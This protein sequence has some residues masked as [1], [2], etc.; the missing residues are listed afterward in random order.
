MALKIPREIFEKLPWLN[1]PDR[2]TRT[3]NNLSESVLSPGQ[4]ENFI[5]KTIELLANGGNSGGEGGSL[6]K[7]LEFSTYISKYTTDELRKKLTK[8][9]VQPVYSIFANPGPPNVSWFVG[10]SFYLSDDMTIC[11][12]GFGVSNKVGKVDGI[13]FGQQ[14]TSGSS[15]NNPDF[16][17]T[18]MTF[19]SE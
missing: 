6:S 12:I 13:F 8:G 7:A 14:S 4:T 16:I 17:W 19:P 15:L 10:L 3:R 5:M 9:S 18:K 2:F 11:I 1:T